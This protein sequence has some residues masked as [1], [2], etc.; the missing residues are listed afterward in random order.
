M[1]KIS[2]LLL[3]ALLS[4]NLV[5]A[6]SKA[7]TK[8]LKEFDTYV[9]N[10]RKQWDAVGLAI[11]VVKDNE[12]I[13]KKAYGVQELNTNQAVDNNTLFACAS[14]TKLMTATCMGML[15]DEGK[16]N[17]DDPVI[18]Y[19][20]EFQL[21][22]PYVTRELRIRDLFLHNSGVG[23]TDFLWAYM[24]ISGEEILER[25]RLVKPSYSFRS[26]FIYQNIFYLAAGQVIEKVSGKPWEE[27]IKERIFS[28]LGM[29]NTYPTLA[30][31]PTA[32]KTKPH[33]KMDG[34]NMVI[35]DMSADAIGPAGSV[36]SSIEDMS[37]WAKSMLDSSKYAGGRL[38]QSKTWEEI[39][40]V[41]TL[42]PPNE[43]YP[44]AQLTHPNFTTY[45][46]GWFQHDYKGKKVNFHTGSLP[47][48]IAIHGQIPEERI[49][50]YVFGN[51]DHV[52]V[53]HALMYKAFDLF[54][55]GGTTDWSSDFLK[56]YT[57][58]NE[59]GE[60]AQKAQDEKRVA[61][62][63]PSL[64]L[65]AYA[66]TYQDELLGEVIVVVASNQ[67]T[68]TIND[69][70]KATL[71]HWNFDTF[72]GPM[73]KKWNGDVTALFQLNSAGEVVAL[74]LAGFTLQKV[75]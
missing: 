41:H 33:L 75:K 74:D 32:N 38:I 30:A 28:P 54:A 58:L 14:T 50:V 70:H 19:L 24:N 67:L 36:W 23:N 59:T 61:N 51:T 20:P 11:T 73:E 4:F 29:N 55:L 63:K 53:R 31:A 65:S 52:E 69:M 12:V 1:K 22:D 27:F 47:G 8:Q 10:S 6:Q 21:Y 60:A 72:K 39:T 48:S 17:W 18:Q 5:F 45:G 56:L 25:M 2:L 57:R 13:F 34:K 66:G 37:K 68:V 42:V 71:S 3:S 9:E 35:E 43:F 64:P 26:S 40:K 16:I 49:A 46:L 44:T 7:L 62:T 15:V